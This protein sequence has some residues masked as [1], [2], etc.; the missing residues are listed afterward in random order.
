M[1]KFGQELTLLAPGDG[2]G[3]GGREGGGGTMYHR[4]IFLLRNKVLKKFF[5]KKLPNAHND[6]FVKSL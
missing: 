5:Q 2:V 3:L 4:G 6:S 1:P